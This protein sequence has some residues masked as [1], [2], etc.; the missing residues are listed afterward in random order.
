[1]RSA[2]DKL[3]SLNEEKSKEIKL[4]KSK[5]DERCNGI[6]KE[7]NTQVT[8]QNKPALQEVNKG[9]ADCVNNLRTVH[10]KLNDLLI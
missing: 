6:L 7:A 8:D 9:L 4:L 5:L 1:M 10:Q 3:E 2:N